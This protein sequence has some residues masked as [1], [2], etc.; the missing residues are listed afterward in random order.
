MA[1]AATHQHRPSVFSALVVAALAIALAHTLR[2]NAALRAELSRYRSTA[3]LPIEDIDDVRNAGLAFFKAHVSEIVVDDVNMLAARPWRPWT[4]SPRAIEMLTVR[5]APGEGARSSLSAATTRRALHRM[6]R[7]GVCL[8]PVVTDEAL[9][10]AARAAVDNETRWPTVHYGG[11][12][13]G[14]VAGSNRRKDIGLRFNTGASD[15]LQRVTQFLKP[16]LSRALGRDATLVEFAGLTSYPGAAMQDAHVDSRMTN[17]AEL[18]STAA[19]WTA[20]VYLTDVTFD[21]AP[22]ELWAGTHTS[23]HFLDSA[24]LA[25]LDGSPALRL[26]VKAGT[27]VLYDSRLEHR[28]TANTSPRARPSVYFSFQSPHGTEPIGPT[29]TIRNEY[30]GA[31]SLGDVLDGSFVER[32]TR[33]EKALRRAA[34]YRN[35][36]AVG[37]A[38]EMTARCGSS[39]SCMRC[40]TS[41]TRG[42]VVKTQLSACVE[43]LIE[44]FCKVGIFSDQ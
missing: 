35:V 2:T 39:Q 6:K 28:G 3:L 5:L 42:A 37:C 20:F 15:V 30:F 10:T 4:A 43:G 27:V 9:L 23:Y 40:A 34:L 12:D 13:G 19:L 18:N 1:T 11:A 7:F 25:M 29:Y 8:F 22:L 16:V 26:A 21:M 38:A 33:D 41:R 31:A 44:R 36:S 32:Q 24:E 14:K 17:L